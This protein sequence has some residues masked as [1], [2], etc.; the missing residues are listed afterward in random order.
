MLEEMDLR[1]FNEL[2]PKL[3]R[4][5]APTSLKDHFFLATKRTHW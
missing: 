3:T 5:M 4:V 1:S 2:E